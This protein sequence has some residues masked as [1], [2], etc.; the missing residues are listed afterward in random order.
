[1]P[2]LPLSPAMVLVA[3]AACA[4]ALDPPCAPATPP[5]T[6]SE[7]I[8]GLPSY[9]SPGPNVTAGLRDSTGQ[10]VSLPGGLAYATAVVTFEPGSPAPTPDAADPLSALGPPDYAVDTQAPPRAVSVGNGGTL[11]LRFDGPGLGDTPGPDL[12]VFEIGAPEATEVAISDD[13]VA[14]RELGRIPGGAMAIDIAP[15]T[16]EGEAFH[17][18][19]LHD[20]AGEGPESPAFPGAD[21]DAV[22]VRAGQV[23]RVA[24]PGRVLFDFDDDRLTTTEALD[25]VLAEI[26]QR[27]GSRVTVEGHTDEIGTADYNQRLSERRAEAVAAFL[28]E[29]GVARERLVIRGFGAQRPL[30]MGRDEGRRKQ[31]RRVEI[32]IDGR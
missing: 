32:V 24:I 12:F 20:A 4:P 26:A 17:Y 9:Q 23:R 27:P 14:W 31:N 13:G 6:E 1:M 30:V 16:K 2:R 8:A 19:R 10:T 18:V 29:H 21:V 7:I 3:L 11:V 28:V 5:P 15:V 22:G 25:G